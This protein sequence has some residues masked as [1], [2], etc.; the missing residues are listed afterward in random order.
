M[1]EVLVG[2]P[3]KGNII[4][5]ALTIG[6][7][8]GIFVY[9]GL[10]IALH[11]SQNVPLA[12]GIT[13][14][15]IVASFVIG[16]AIV[17]RRLAHLET[18]LSEAQIGDDGIYLQEEVDYETGV[19]SAKGYWSSSGRNRTY[20]VQSKF[21]GNEK[22]R[23]SRI[24]LPSGKFVVSVKRNDEGYISAPAVR[25]GGKY[26]G[27]IVMALDPRGTVEG[28]GTLTATYG[29]D[30]ATL[31]FEG[32]GSV[33]EGKVSS[34]LG[35]AK[36]SRVELYHMDYPSN[37][38]RIAAGLNYTFSFNPFKWL[39]RGKRNVIVTV[40]GF[41]PREFRRLFG[42]GEYLIGHGRYGIR[43][44]LDIPM[45]RDVVEEASFE[46]LPVG[47]VEG[48]EESESRMLPT[49]IERIF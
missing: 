22:G 31:T 35:K 9:K 39:K 40:Q 18:F 7:V 11:I 4:G 43:L 14:V 1:V 48:S 12:L 30:Y 19:Y 33:L 25:L 26:D 34:S 5:A 37:H 15:F 16:L 6:A 45:R 44:I 36:R 47:R 46:V 2:K 42:L 3:S 17:R 13:A 27:V 10:E 41:S 20:R 23:A 28:G 49:G 29:D 8:A 38:F 21:H 24:P 32:K